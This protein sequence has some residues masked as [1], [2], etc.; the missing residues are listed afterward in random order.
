V[1]LIDSAP[2][3]TQECPMPPIKRTLKNAA[4]TT[5]NV[6]LGTVGRLN[7]AATKTGE[8][9]AQG[10]KTVKEAAVL[11]AKSVPAA[12]K[13]TV[14]NPIGAAKGAGKAIKN[15]AAS[16]TVRA[17][18]LVRRGNAGTAAVGAAMTVTG[19]AIPVGAVVGA[20]RAKKK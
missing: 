20:A 8:Q 17:P 13:N 4:A 9:I 6:A 18:G 1:R 14:T 12:A 19:L 7:Y 16:G 5:K 2:T 15:I 3:P 11:G 10:A